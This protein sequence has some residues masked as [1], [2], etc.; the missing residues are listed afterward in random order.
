MLCSWSLLKTLKK[1]ELVVDFLNL[2]SRYKGGNINL[3]APQSMDCVR[4]NMTTTMGCFNHTGLLVF[5]FCLPSMAMVAP[6][7]NGTPKLRVK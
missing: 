6:T 4:D 3:K 2:P 1:G 7:Q 5:L